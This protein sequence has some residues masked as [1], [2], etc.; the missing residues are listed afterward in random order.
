[1]G[2]IVGELLPLGQAIAGGSELDAI[3]EEMR[4]GVELLRLPDSAEPYTAEEVG[5]LRREPL[6]DVA[7]VRAA[8]VEGIR[9]N[10]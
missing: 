7:A 6:L 5:R 8:L 10:P 3:L 4:R 2:A 1:M 9:R